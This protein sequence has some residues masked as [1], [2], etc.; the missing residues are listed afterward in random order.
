MH[1]SSLTLGRARL[2][3]KEN[4]AATMALLIHR[5]LRVSNAFPNGFETCRHHVSKPMVF[6]VHHKSIPI[7]S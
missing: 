5:N 2:A 6:L 1:P 7:Y 3:K 4:N